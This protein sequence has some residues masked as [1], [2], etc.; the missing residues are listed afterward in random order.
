MRHIMVF[1]RALR[2]SYQMCSRA[3][4]SFRVAYFADSV[5][6]A[7]QLAHLNAIMV[8]HDVRQG[9]GWIKLCYDFTSPNTDC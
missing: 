1:R 4:P 3:I 6:F 8:F 5:L 9:Q 2:L 7:L